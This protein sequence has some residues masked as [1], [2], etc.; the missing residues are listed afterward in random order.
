M[1]AS[2]SDGRGRSAY[3]HALPKSPRPVIS[4]RW[5]FGRHRHV[6]AANRERLCRPATMQASKATEQ[7]I[8]RP[9]VS[10]LTYAACEAPEYDNSWL[11]TLG[12]HFLN[13]L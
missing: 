6:I 7:Q 3:R 4:L 9:N 13:T 12:M 11:E 5:V 1:A 8:P 10:N 2:S